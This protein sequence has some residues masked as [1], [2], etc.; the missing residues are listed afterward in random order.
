MKKT[1]N[2]NNLLHQNVKSVFDGIEKKK[3]WMEQN[4][5]SE[6]LGTNIMVEWNETKKEIEL[7]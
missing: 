4:M 5:G 1:S 3:L 2:R 7:W 6:C